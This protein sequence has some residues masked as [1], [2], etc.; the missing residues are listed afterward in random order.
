MQADQTSTSGFLVRHSKAIVA[1]KHFEHLIAAAILA[2]AVFVGLHTSSTLTERFD[3][4]LELANQAFLG[5]FILEAAIKLTAH[6]PRVLNYFKNPWNDF[7]FTI[8]VVRL[9]TTSAELATAARL[10]RLMRLLR[11]VSVLPELRMI[12]STLFRSIPSMLNILVLISIIFYVYAV[13]GFYLFNQVDP[14][15]WSTLGVSL[16]SLF[17]IVTLEDWTDIM[18]AAMEELRWAWIYFVSFIVVATF[19]VVN[20]FIAVV[21]SNLDETKK[22]LLRDLEGP[23]S[24]EELL[25]ELS[26]TRDALERLQQR[27]ESDS[28][29][30]ST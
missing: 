11:L 22:E 19:V 6:F 5:F 18:Y 17:R 20:L 9:F 25:S 15:H 13:A 7:D 10:L 30:G 8:I 16:L 1:W 29:Q 12:V 2:N 27:I 21:V 28:N 14:E 24:R 23:T 3:F 4:W 26:R